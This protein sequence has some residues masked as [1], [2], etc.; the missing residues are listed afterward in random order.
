[1]LGQMK[2][3]EML[4]VL[5]DEPGTRNVPD[6]VRK[7]G[8]TVVSITPERAHWRFSGI[9]TFPCAK[10]SAKSRASVA[11]PDSDRQRTESGETGEHTQSV[12]YPFHP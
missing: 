3:G 8:H 1:V 9:A 2:S 12:K 5:L 4:A 6:S 7:D 10:D 11:V